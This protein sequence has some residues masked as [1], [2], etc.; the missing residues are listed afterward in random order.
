MKGK[1][2]KINGI[3]PVTITSGVYLDNSN[4]TLKQAIDNGGGT[5]VD[6]EEVFVVE[7][8]APSDPF[9]LNTKPTSEDFAPYQ[10]K[11]DTSLITNDKTVV[12]AINETAYITTKFTRIPHNIAENA[13]IL[14]SWFID[15]S[16]GEGKNLASF[17]TVVLNVKGNTKYKYEHTDNITDNPATNLRAR[18]AAFYDID[19]RFIS[20]ITWYPELKISTP[21]NAVKMRMC[22]AYIDF[23]T[24]KK[25]N[26]YIALEDDKLEQV[27]ID[28]LKIKADNLTDILDL[29]NEGSNIDIRK[30]SF[31]FV[32]DDGNATDK[33]LK[34]VFDKFDFKCGFALL[35]NDSLETKKD[36]YLQMQREGFEILSHSIDGK[37]M[38]E[39]TDTVEVIENKFKTSKDILEKAGFKIRGW[40]TPSTWL[41]SAYFDTLKKY[42]CYGLG[43]LDSNNTDVVHTLK[44]KDIRQLDRWSL[45]SNTIEQTKA[46]ID[47]CI[48][49]NGFLCFYAH[50]Y[51]SEDNF[52]EANLLEILKYLK[53]KVDSKEI[54]VNT[55]YKIIN[56]YYKIRQYDLL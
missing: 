32:F 23:D 30:P 9:I 3:F 52:T 4:K 8:E 34:K 13:E 56:Q 40:V 5:K 1:I 16:N 46:K 43:H 51:P 22:F 29:I 53:S 50:N 45:Q 42:Y 28:G 14:E 33:D 11:Q 7:E 15:G 37:P 55:P 31:S 39:N 41:N 49:K 27:V 54:I 10:K 17:F 36:D 35:G 6:P 24:K 21:T 19:D 26:Y 44:S 18:S 38:Q 47:E 48:S 12:G 20:G 2:K 25:G